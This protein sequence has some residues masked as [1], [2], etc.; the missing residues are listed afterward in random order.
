VPPPTTSGPIR[1][2]PRHSGTAPAAQSADRPSLFARIW[3]QWRLF[4]D[5]K[6]GQRFRNYRRN[7]HRHASSAVRCVCV[8][9]GLVLLAAGV[10]MLFM[11]GPGVLVIFLGLAMFAGESKALA[12]WLDRLEPALRRKGKAAV[13]W[14]NRR[15]IPVRV[16]LVGVAMALTGLA[17][18]AWWIQFGP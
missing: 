18:R 14:W 5:D 6:P 17:M 13:A 15:P 12:G 1:V 8:V 9:A 7:L 11:P 10:V 3:R 4:R 16:L 2:R